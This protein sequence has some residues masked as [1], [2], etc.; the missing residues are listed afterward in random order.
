[1]AW[2]EGI[3]KTKSWHR[4]R[5]RTSLA[6]L[7][8]MATSRYYDGTGSIVWYLD[9]TE[10]K[11]NWFRILMPRIGKL[12]PKLGIPHFQRDPNGL[13]PKM[14]NFVGLLIPAR[15]THILLMWQP[16]SYHCGSEFA[17][18]F[19]ILWWAARQPNRSHTLIA[20]AKYRLHVCWLNWL[21]LNPTS[22]G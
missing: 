1:M 6:L 5:T 7:R 14:T 9:I 8:M 17:D 10:T 22:R 12:D 15:L 21:K 18:R 11:I 2:I 20:I 13:A 4:T 16:T 3:T 19:N